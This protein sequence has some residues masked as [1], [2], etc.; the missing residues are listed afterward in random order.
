[1]I[2]LIRVRRGPTGRFQLVNQAIVHRRI[3]SLITDDHKKRGVPRRAFS[4]TDQSPT[5][6]SYTIHLGPTGTPGAYTVRRGHCR[7]ARALQCIERGA[8]AVMLTL[9]LGD[10][11]LG[12]GVERDTHRTSAAT[13]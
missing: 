4:V 11:G 8:V 10:G 12:S 13:H 6:E 1:M 7:L 3:R 9:G 5:G 2:L